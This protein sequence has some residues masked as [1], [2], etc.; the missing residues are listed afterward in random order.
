MSEPRQ[1]NPVYLDIE[2]DAPDPMDFTPKV[3]PVPKGSFAPGF[4]GISPSGPPLPSEQ[5][6]LQSNSE[7]SLTT[8]QSSLLN[9]PNPS[10]G[11]AE[12]PES[13][14]SAEKAPTTPETTPEPSQ[15]KAPETTPEKPKQR[16]TSSV[17]SPPQ[18]S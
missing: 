3:T 10:S 7:G 13:P 2:L 18:V 12:T 14:A 11:N 6:S 9:G 8:L 15:E 5:S 17:A 16:P 4:V 1:I